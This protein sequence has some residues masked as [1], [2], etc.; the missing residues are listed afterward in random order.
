VKRAR[1]LF[2]IG[3][4]DPTDNS[5]AQAQWAAREDSRLNLEVALG[6][7]DNTFEASAQ[8][9]YQGADFRSAVDNARLWQRDQPFEPRPAQFG[10]FLASE[11]L[12][13]HTTAI[14]LARNG[15]QANPQNAGLINNLA[16][17]YLRAGQVEGASDILGNLRLHG[18]PPEELI[19]ALATLGLL[20]YRQGRPDIGRERYIHAGDVAQ[21]AKR[22]DL[23]V[24]ASI[25]M[26]NEEQRLGSPEA[27]DDVALAAARAEEVIV[28][29]NPQAELIRRRLRWLIQGGDDGPTRR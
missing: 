17:S 7:A 8:D 25:Y 12:D 11:G 3:L 28:D 16:F 22:P 14:E 24:F 23:L 10:S 15:W 2:R 21:D 20:A 6:G 26:A 18:L 1:K 19:P 27:R 13:D 29:D 5:I 4:E 9:A